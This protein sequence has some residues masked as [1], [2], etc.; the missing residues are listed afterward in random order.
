MKSLRYHLSERG[1][2]GETRMAGLHF[3]CGEWFGEDKSADPLFDIIG[4]ELGAFVTEAEKLAWCEQ[5][6]RPFNRQSRARQLKLK[7]KMM[8]AIAEPLRR[9]RDELV[10]R[11]GLSGPDASLEE[12]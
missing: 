8:Q 2:G 11:L 10:R 4:K 7:P 12:L 3:S 6:L 5:F 9:Y 1:M